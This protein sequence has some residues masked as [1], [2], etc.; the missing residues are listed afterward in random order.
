MENTYVPLFLSAID[1]VV[2]DPNISLNQACIRIQNW[3]YS[4]SV[5]M[6]EHTNI[7]WCHN[8]YTLNSQLS[9]MK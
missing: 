9:V 8:L 1:K 4:K 6:L 5:R 2:F 3:L 7:E